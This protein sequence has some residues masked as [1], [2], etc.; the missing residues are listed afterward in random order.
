MYRTIAL[1]LLLLLATNSYA[2]KLFWG[3]SAIS[4][5]ID[6]TLDDGIT[7]T[8]TTDDATGFGIYA[9]SYYQNK[10]R[11]NGTLSYID[12]S[13]FS[14]T[15]ATV[16]ADYLLPVNAQAT[17]FVGATIGG[18]SQTYS[19]SGIGDSA[20]DA[21][22]GLQTGAIMLISNKVMLEAGY[23]L[24]FTGLETEFTGTTIMSTVDELNEAYISL[25]ILM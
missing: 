13:S 2:S 10:Y 7:T 24:K 23:R 5:K 19:N 1:L 21:L 22:Y 3:I 25:T 20:F 12:Y 18:A 6:I 14:I 16:S 4:Q 8:R 17:I 9:D 15:S 11:L